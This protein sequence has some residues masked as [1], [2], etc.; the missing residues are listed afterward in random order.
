M[1]TRPSP[2]DTRTGSTRKCSPGWASN[3]RAPSGKPCTLLPPPEVQFIHCVAVLVLG[4]FLD[5]DEMEAFEDKLGRTMAWAVF[6]GWRAY[7]AHVSGSLRLPD[8]NP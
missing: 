3:T 1:M 5:V 6:A 7:E 4:T 8:E 2:T